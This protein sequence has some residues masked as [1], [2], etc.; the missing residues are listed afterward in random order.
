MIT[1]NIGDCIIY[2][3]NQLIA[4]NKPAGIASQ[5]EPSGE[6]SMLDLLEIY[7][8]HKLFVVHRLDRPASGVLL[9]AKNKQA[10]ARLHE[11]FKERKV[12]KTYL[13]VV[14]QKPDQ[15]EGELSHFLKYDTKKKKTFVVDPAVG[16][17]AVL[18]YKW[19]DSSEKLFLLEVNLLTGRQ[20]QIR[21]QMAAIGLPI[22]GDDKYGFKRGN[23]DRSIQLHAWKLAFKHP[24]SGLD[25]H[26]AASLPMLPVWDAF[27][28]PK[29]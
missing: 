22:R 9:F 2:N 27:N 23:K 7:C 18:Q 20:H 12:S 10:V 1:T 3:N 17:E 8:K 15:E 25:V 13:A 19:V 16:Q 6:K 21:A 14:G 11:Q 26:L 29:I 5:P 4:V 28:Y 24:V